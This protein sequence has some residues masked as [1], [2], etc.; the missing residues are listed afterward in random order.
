MILDYLS[1]IVLATLGVL[2]LVSGLWLLKKHKQNE[3]DIAAIMYSITHDEL[4]NPVQSALAT[5]GNLENRIDMQNTHLQKDV[6][7][8]RNSLIR[9]T[10]VIHNLRALALLEVPN[11]SRITERINLVGIVQKLIVEHGDKAERKNVRLIYEGGD[12]AIYLLAKKEDLERLFSNL[13]DNGIKYRRRDV[14]DAFIVVSITPQTR[15]VQIVVSDNG[16]GIAADRL[17]SLGQAPQRPV[18]KNVGTRGVGLGLF[19]TRKIVESYQGTLDVKSTEDRGTTVTV[20]LP[21]YAG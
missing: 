6:S 5:V 17:A 7:S 4:S 21:A 12:S 18:A 3:S 15:K 11:T 19:L 13:I 1:S 9:L 16:V 14:Q 2:G 20:T 8:L 10:A